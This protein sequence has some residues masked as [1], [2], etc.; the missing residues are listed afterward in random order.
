MR[1]LAL[2]AVLTIGAPPALAQGLSPPQQPPPAEV[3]CV[4][5]GILSFVGIAR[6]LTGAHESG[7]LSI[8]VTLQ[9]R[10]PRSAAFVMNFTA[11]NVQ[12]PAVN[13]W[14]TLETQARG[15]YLVGTLPRGT[16]VTDE[17]LR[18]HLQLRCVR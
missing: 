7:R 15:T 4:A 1:R 6:E 3:E 8:T 14:R 9:N 12:M 11:P 5:A 17:E 18:G 13:Q 2:L 10:T 16:L